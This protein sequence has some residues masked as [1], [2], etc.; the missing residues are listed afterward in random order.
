MK[1][2]VKIVALAVLF[3]VGPSPCFGRWAVLLV[4]K[5]EAKEFG[6][7]VR[8]TATGSN[9]V[10]VE[11]EFKP[12]GYFKEYS[13][14]ELWIGEGDNPRVTA[15]LREDRSKAGHIVVGFSVDRVQLDQSNL[16]LI[17]PHSG[18]GAKGVTYMLRVKDFVE[19]KKG[20]S[21][22]SDASESLLG[23]WIAEKVLSAGQEVPEEKFPFELHLT[24][25]QLTYKFVGGTKGKD[26]VHDIS[27]DSSKTPAAIDITR[28]VG[29]KKMTVRG[30]YKYEDGRLFICFLRAANENPSEDRPSTFESTSEI[31]SDL[32]ILKRKPKGDK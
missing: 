2:I 32:L 15:P 3:G 29:A 25:S 22:A 31:K 10:T 5:E 27:L 14:V 19:L 17:V 28:T 6:M 12:E 8:T 7:Q 1:T 21:L 13:R 26:R 11:L 20:R 9:Q 30:I 24:E 16:R 23:V 4:S 18:G